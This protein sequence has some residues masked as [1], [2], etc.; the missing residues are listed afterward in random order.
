MSE[1]TN[2]DIT[3]KKLDAMRVLK[4]DDNDKPKIWVSEDILYKKDNDLVMKLHKEDFEIFSE[5]EELKNCVFPTNTFSVDKKFFGYITPYYEEYKPINY[6]MYKNKYS[7]NQKKKLM[8]KVVKLVKALNDLDIVHADLNTC[9]IIC[10][11][12]DIKLIDFDRIKIKEYEDKSIYDW[13]IKDQIY[14]L[15]VALITMLL[16]I[17]LARIMNSEFKELINGLSFSNEFKEYL[18]NSTTHKVNEIPNELFEYIDSINKKD[19]SK[20]KELIKTLHL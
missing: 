2:I 13:R 4:Y 3:R 16:D 9:N 5:Y 15:N 12:K 17:N 8:K 18:L 1:I 6:R 11:G 10:N 20:G 7:V 19:I 14:Y